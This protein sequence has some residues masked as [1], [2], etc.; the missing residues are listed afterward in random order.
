M[1]LKKYV[2]KNKLEENMIWHWMKKKSG[3]SFGRV[4]KSQ[5]I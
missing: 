3:K 5:K 4:Q 2:V 1:L